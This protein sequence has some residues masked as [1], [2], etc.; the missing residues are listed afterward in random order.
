MI[1]RTLLVAV[2]LLAVLALLVLVPSQAWVWNRDEPTGGASGEALALGWQDLLPDGFEPPEDPFRTITPEELDKLF[3]G[4]EESQ[5]ELAELEERMR[6]APV[7]E[8]L[9]GKLVT[10]PG[11]VVP[12]EF[13]GQ[14]R[15][16]EFLLVPYFGACIHTPPPPANQIVMASLERPVEIADTYEPVS[17]RGILRTESTTSD[18]AEAGYRMD[19][20][21]VERY[22]P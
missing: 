5:Q 14:T 13:D 9:D 7:D 8:T 16:E 18:L 19:V 2:P 20:L 11:Y 10:L 3:D 6:Y 17:L 4:S 22:E 21:A 12:L 1:K 15:L